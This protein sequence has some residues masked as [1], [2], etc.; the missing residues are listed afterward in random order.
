MMIIP[1][2]DIRDGKCVRLFQGDFAKQTTYSS[3][4]LEVAKQWKKQGAALIHVVDLDGAKDGSPK[5][6]ELIIRMAKELAIPIEVGGGI[7][8]K[9]TIQKYLDSGIARVVIGTAALEDEQFVKEIVSIFG[10]KIVVG[11]DAKNGELMQNGWTAGSGKNVLDLAKLL[12]DIGVKRIIYTD[13]QR[14]GTL[15]SPNFDGIKKLIET[16]AIPIVASGG[17]TKLGDIK[18]LTTLDVEGVIIGK[19]FYEE[20]IDLQD[21]LKASKGWIPGSRPGMTT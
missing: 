8:D 20:R 21:A 12:E 15:T 19:A 10:E 13:I 6:M 11:L 1:A 17:V 7:R 4:P 3:P 2:I 9:E 18:N 14:D 5:N 16:V